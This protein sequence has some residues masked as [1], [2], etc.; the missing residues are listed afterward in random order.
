[1]TDLDRALLDCIEVCGIVDKKIFS[2]RKNNSIL[3]DE[4]VKFSLFLTLEPNREQKSFIKKIT[5]TNSDLR[6]LYTKTTQIG[7]INETHPIVDNFI[8][9]DIMYNSTGVDTNAD[10]TNKLKILL[11]EYGNTLI[12]KG[13]IANKE[14]AES[15]L[16]LFMQR[17]DAD[18]LLKTTDFMN[19]KLNSENNNPTT[20][21]SP[22]AMNEE[23]ED[24]E[25][26]EVKEDPR[27]LQELIQELNDL[28]GLKFVKKE[29][30]SLIHLIKISNMRKEKGMQVASISKHMVFTGNPG[31][32]KTTV[33][34]LIA[35]IYHKLG[36]LTKG[37]L[38]ETDRAALVAGYVGQTAI[39]TEQVITQA[40]GG[41]LFIDE[42]YTLSANKGEGDFGQEAIDTLLKIM[43]DNRDDLVVIV[44]GYPDLMEEFLQSNP[45]LKSRF[46]KF[47]D[48]QN[49]S[50]E[51]L[52]NIFKGMCKK[53]EYELSE[54][55][56][57]KLKEKIQSILDEESESFANARTMRNLLEFTILNQADR[58]IKKY[59]DEEVSK[60][61]NDV[62]KDVSE[63]KVNNT[64]SDENFNVKTNDTEYEISDDDLKMLLPEDFMDYNLG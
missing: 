29:L 23:M 25:V 38:V 11:N 48:F 44:A 21:E 43:E 49:Y 12:A 47:I 15:F 36:V 6:P 17:I 16:V 8:S 55:T 39:K 63:E 51:E 32:G 41:V 62:D 37:Q 40:L 10:K 18:K 9:L 20:D 45:G 26:V 22:F 31:T 52:L 58:L 27:T 61:D 13:D 46:N 4:L 50:V 1:M 33:A 60:E 57:I 2:T 5:K 34:R 53:Q 14:R 7:Y 3:L 28:T 59:E 56:E 24:S 35:G 42:A 30:N 54:E 64:E 19:H